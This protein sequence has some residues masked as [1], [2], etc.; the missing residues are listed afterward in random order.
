MTRIIAALVIAATAGAAAIP[1]ARAA[2]PAMPITPIQKAELA[3]L[4]PA[5]RKKVEARLG[6]GQTVRGVLDT[7][8]LNGVSHD[9]ADGTIVASDFDRGTVVVQGKDGT[10]HSVPFTVETLEIRK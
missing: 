6:H 10:M 1:P 4:N 2:E 3:Q 7:M 9:F 8:L 5:L